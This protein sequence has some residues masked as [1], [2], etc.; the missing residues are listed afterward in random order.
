MIKFFEK[1]TAEVGK[2][3]DLSVLPE[4]DS[5]KQ[6]ARKIIDQSFKKIAE[7]YLFNG[8]LKVKAE[9]VD[10]A[11]NIR[12]A[13]DKILADKGI[14][15][16]KRKQAVGYINN[17]IYGAVTRAILEH[18]KRVDGRAL[19]EIRTLSCRVGVLP[20][21][22]GSALFQAGRNSSAFHCHF[23]C[24]GH[25]AVSGYDGRKRPQK[26]YASL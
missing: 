12:Q 22:H 20:R 6:E 5:E 23:R 24:A 18:G 3:K 11:E 25:G 16:E 10:A 19:D 17:L 21:V 15:E 7:K 9:R 1:I 2:K 13:M 8:P 14:E 4:I 26:I